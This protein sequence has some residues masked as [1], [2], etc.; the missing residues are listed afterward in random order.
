MTKDRLKA[1]LFY[2][3][4]RLSQE[5][6]SVESLLLDKGMKNICI[7]GFDI[8]GECLLYELENSAIDIRFFIDKTGER[9]FVDFPIYTLDEAKSQD[10][11]AVDGIIVSPVDDYERITSDLKKHGINVKIVSLEDLLYEI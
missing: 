2:R 6:I 4:I 9:K 3:W 8:M 10:Y 5:G 7:Y 11:S 1:E